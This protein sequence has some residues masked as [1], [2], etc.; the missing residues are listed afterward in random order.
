M[1]ILSNYENLSTTYTPNNVDT[2][3]PECPQEIKC[4]NPNK[5]INARGL[6]V[7]YEIN[8]NDNVVIPFTINKS[9]K[10]PLTAIVYREASQSPDNTVEGQYGQKAYNIID[11][12]SYTCYGYN[13]NGYIWEID[14]VFE[15]DACGERCVTLTPNMSSNILEVNIYDFRGNKILSNSDFGVNTL[16]WNFTEKEYNKLRTGIFDCEINLITENYSK[17]IGKLKLVIV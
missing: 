7:G 3:S 8:F 2:F 9:I 14:N 11:C 1:G 5:I 13:I 6:F 15:W 16:N 12:K 4:E 17:V 10:V